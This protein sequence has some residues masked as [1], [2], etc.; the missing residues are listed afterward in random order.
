[1]EDDETKRNQ[2]DL[3]LFGKLVSDLGNLKK[4]EL[5]MST[6]ELLCMKTTCT[7]ICKDITLQ[8]TKFIINHHSSTTQLPTQPTLLTFFLL[9]GLG[10]LRFADPDLQFFF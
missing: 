4:G 10:A 8:N 7:V 5:V 2:A 9:F 3:D 6:F 1:M